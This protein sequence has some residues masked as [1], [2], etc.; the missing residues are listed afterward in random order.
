MEHIMK[1][2]ENAFERI[3]SGEKKREYR[4]NG[5]QHGATIHYIEN[6][7]YIPFWIGIKVISFG[8]ISE[9][10]SVLKPIDKKEV[11]DVYHI[12]PDEMQV[13]LPILANYRNLCAHEDILYDHRAQ[14]DINDTVYHANLKIPKMNNEYIYGKNDLFA[15]IIIMKQLFLSSV[16]E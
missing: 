1:L 15:L 12:E 7:G 13:Y 3:K 16:P 6:Y 8:L 2:N 10:V 9:M 4:V 14:R 5:L 11:A